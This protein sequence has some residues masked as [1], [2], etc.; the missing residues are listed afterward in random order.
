MIFSHPKPSNYYQLKIPTRNVSNTFTRAHRRIC[1][2]FCCARVEDCEEIRAKACV[3]H[4]CTILNNF[5]SNLLIYACVTMRTY[6]HT[7]IDFIV[8]LIV[9]ICEI[10]EIHCAHIQT[11]ANWVCAMYPI[12]VCVHERSGGQ[13][14]FDK[15][16]KRFKHDRDSYSQSCDTIAWLY[17]K[18][19]LKACI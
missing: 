2:S 5:S 17:N 6:T 1:R 15:L 12:H 7:H 10:R 4:L 3:L 8:C 14:N 13:K 19:G 9:A 18:K 11:L 16:W